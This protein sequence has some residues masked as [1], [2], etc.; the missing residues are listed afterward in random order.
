MRKYL[1][2]GVVL[3]AFFI[4]AVPCLAGARAIPAFAAVQQAELTVTDSPEPLLFGRS[5]A[6][7]GDTALVSSAA[8]SGDGVVYVFVRSRGKWTRQAKLTPTPLIRGGFGDAIALS[9]DTA[10][11]GDVAN[12][13][14]YVFVRTGTSWSQQATLTRSAGVSYYYFGWSVA[15]SGD[16][17][18]VSAPS[19]GYQG[20]VLIFTRSQ[21][22]WTRQG[23]LWDPEPENSSEFGETLTLSNDTLLVGARSQSVNGVFGAGVVYAYV[24]SASVWLQQAILTNPDSDQGWVGFGENISLSRDTA[25]LGAGI[26]AGDVQRPGAYVFT[27]ADGAWSLQGQLVAPRGNSVS[28][29]V[30]GDTAV[31]GVEDAYSSG[32]AAYAFLRSGAVWSPPL[33]R[34]S[35]V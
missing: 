29:A 17:L 21:G 27:R 26:K 31:L 28:V 5:V 18:A 19:G 11:V 7:D 4:W 20:V 24:R 2:L 23:T 12:Q 15:V 34:Q 3:V 9:G 30:A 32:G 14:I 22:E 25:V 33:D 8:D 35:V 10:V 16:T 13:I 6:V 1:G